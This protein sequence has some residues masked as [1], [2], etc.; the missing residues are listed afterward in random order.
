MNCTIAKNGRKWSVVLD[1]GE[2]VFN[3][4]TRISCFNYAHENGLEI[5]SYQHGDK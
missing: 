2:V 5:I 3:G 4:K 1:N